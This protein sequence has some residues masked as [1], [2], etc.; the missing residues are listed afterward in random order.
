MKKTIKLLVLLCLLASP[1][2]ASTY[3]FTPSTPQATIVT[4]LAVTGPNTYNFAAGTYTQITATLTF[5]CNTGNVYQGPVGPFVVGTGAAPT[6]I[7]NAAFSSSNLIE[8]T[9][10]NTH[11]TP[12]SGC[13]I[14]GLAFENQNV[15]IAPPVSGLLFQFNKVFNILGQVSG[16]GNTTSWAGVYVGDG[17]PQDIGFSTFQYNTFGPSC[18]D[19]DSSATDYDGTCGGV[20]IQG[21]NV[22]VTVQDNVFANIEE[23]VHTLGQGTG[24]DVS[25]SL[26]VLNNEGVG[27]HRIFIENQQGK[28]TDQQ[29]LHNS[30]HDPLNPFFASFG[31]SQACC[32]ATTGSPVLSNQVNDNVIV[33][34][35]PCMLSSYCMGYAIEAWGNEPTFNNNLIQGHFIGNGI[36]LGGY[37]GGNT[38]SPTAINN[39]IQGGS[40]NFIDCEEGGTLPSCTFVTGTITYTPNTTSLVITPVLSV[41][42][43]ISIA[44]NVVTIT[45]TGTN[46]LAYYTTDGTTPVPGWGST[47]TYVAPFTV[48]AGK[49]VRAVGFWGTGSNPLSYAPGFG[50]I[51]SNIVQAYNGVT[52]PTV[53]SVT[54]VA[55]L[56]TANI[57]QPIKL[58]PSCLYSNGERT[59]CGTTDKYGTLA[60]YAS[61]SPTIGTVSTLGVF[62]GL[63]TGT[64]SVT[65][66]AGG[67]TSPGVTLTVVAT[68]TTMPAGSFGTGAQTT[69]GTLNSGFFAGNYITVGTV[70]VTPKLCTFYVGTGITAGQQI[71]CILVL[72]PTPTTQNSNATCW[73]TYVAP[74]TGIPANQWVSVPM[75]AQCP[76]LPA[77]TSYWLWQAAQSSPSLGVTGCPGGSNCTGN[78]TSGNYGSAYFASSYG[79]YGGYAS[80]IAG[81]NTNQDSVYLTTTPTR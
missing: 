37:S 21:A 54:L 31:V 79:S 52:V 42:P 20:I 72:A 18:T 64:S 56:T 12:G 38:V 49:L 28:T 55:D 5:P 76:S 4:D 26:H 41:A 11:T 2:L 51:P 22:N 14:Q 8:I 58:K 15:Y 30:Y 44:S 32:I 1:A 10:D 13:T 39:V 35:S 71:D 53:S 17:T 66:T 73:G 67:Q 43:T 75:Q 29:I 16:G 57:G 36:S 80:S 25:T 46:T 63:S 9:G 62:S 74:A 47:Q 27:I 77:Y 65:A 78:A 70:A 24:G 19:L 69:V 34:N 68:G 33:S 6:V 48:A 3:N 7:L 45:E 40:G 61:G 50:Y 60:T 59:F 81:Q 23:A